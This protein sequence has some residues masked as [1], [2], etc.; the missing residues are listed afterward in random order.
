MDYEML[1]PFLIVLILGFVIGMQGTLTY[2]N[3]P[4]TAFAGSRT[5]ALIALGGFI[6]GWLQ[7]FIPGFVLIATYR[8]YCN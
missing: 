5:F 1:K 6:S 3:T 8:I 2:F 4:E 7:T